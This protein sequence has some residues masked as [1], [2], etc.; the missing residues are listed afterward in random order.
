MQYYFNH[1]SSGT[2]IAAIEEWLGMGKFLEVT[3]CLPPKQEFVCL[4][5]MLAEFSGN[6]WNSECSVRET[7]TE[8]AALSYIAH[9]N[10]LQKLKARIYELYARDETEAGAG[11]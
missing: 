6:C 7:W 8:Q 2:N 4:V 10:S 3:Q 11:E 9:V 5:E 1:A